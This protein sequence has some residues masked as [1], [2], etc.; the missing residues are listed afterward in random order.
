MSKLGNVRIRK[1]SGAIVGTRRLLN[2]IEGA[3][4]TLTIADDG[5]ADEVDITIAA[6][7]AAAT[8]WID[9]FFPAVNP[10]SNKGTYASFLMPDDNV[11]TVRQTFIIPSDVATFETAAV[12][13]IPN[14]LGNLYWSVATTFGEVCAGE[15]YDTHSDSIALNAGGVTAGEIEC[16][17][18]TAALTG[19]L[20]GDLVGVEFVRDS[21]DVLDTIVGDV[22]FIGILIQGSV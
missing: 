15:Q 21:V 17:D 11:T 22:H 3:N 16:V 12:V 7:G 1:N 4:V 20:G 19:A 2:L 8:A 6:A 5:P 9:Q 18:I 14:A 13:L 10:N